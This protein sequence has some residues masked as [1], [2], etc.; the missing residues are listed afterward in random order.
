MTP[1]QVVLSHIVLLSLSNEEDLYYFDVFKS[2]PVELI[3]CINW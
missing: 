2:T 3:D 1:A